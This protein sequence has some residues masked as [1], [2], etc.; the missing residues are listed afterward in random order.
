MSYRPTGSGRDLYLV[1]GHCR[2]YPHYVSTR[3]SGMVSV[4]VNAPPGK[5]LPSGSGRDI[6]LMQSPPKR[7]AG[8]LMKDKANRGK[9]VKR[10]GYTKALFTESIFPEKKPRPY[11]SYTARD[12][13][14]REVKRQQMYMTG[15]AQKQTQGDSASGG[16]VSTSTKQQRPRTANVGSGIRRKK[17][18]QR[19][20]FRDAT[21]GRFKG[22]YWGGLQY[23]G[24]VSHSLTWK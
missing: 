11:S 6:Y 8:A 20:K 3:S 24:G 19:Q 16:I 10:M 4:A 14:N 22:A 5:V 9:Q 12:R 18:K 1:G 15:L 23:A 17:E 2:V 13:K 7:G 21:T